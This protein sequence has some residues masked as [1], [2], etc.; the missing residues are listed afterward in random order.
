MMPSLMITRDNFKALDSN[1]GT[2]CKLEPAS[3]CPIV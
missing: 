3:K 1:A 2:S